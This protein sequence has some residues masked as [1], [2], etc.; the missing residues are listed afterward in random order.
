M[1]E[2]RRDEIGLSLEPESSIR[3]RASSIGHSPRLGE[4]RRPGKSFGAGCVVRPHDGV[5]KLQAEVDSWRDAGGTHL[6]IV[7]MGIGLDSMDAH[8]RYIESVA[9]ALGLR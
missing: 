5:G 9:A 7:T 3:C 8:L 1:L 2:V 6:S 4:V